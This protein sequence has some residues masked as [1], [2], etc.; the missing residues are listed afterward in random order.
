MKAVNDHGGSDKLLFLKKVFA[1]TLGDSC[2][3]PL[4]GSVRRLVNFSLRQIRSRPRP[5][6]LFLWAEKPAAPGGKRVSG[7]RRLLMRHFNAPREYEPDTVALVV[8]A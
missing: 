2:Q 7:C 6:S 4:V 5:A 3:L 8:R 1:V